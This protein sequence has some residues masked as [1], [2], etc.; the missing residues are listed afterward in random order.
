MLEED[1]ST[2]NVLVDEFVKVLP[3]FFEDVFL[4]K[5]VFQCDI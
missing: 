2:E 3:G 5:E 1:V 4:E